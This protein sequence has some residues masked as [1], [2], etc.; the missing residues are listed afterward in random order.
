MVFH[1]ENLLQCI[2]VYFNHNPKKHLEFAKWVEIMEIK[3]NKILRNIKTKW[4]SMFNLVKHVLFEYCTLLMKMAL[5]APTI[6][7]T[8]S[9]LCLL[10]NVEMLLG[11]NVVMPLLEVMHSLIKFAQLQDMFMCDFITTVKI[12]E[13]EV[14]RMYYDIHS[15]F[16]GDVFMNF[17]PLIDCVHESIIFC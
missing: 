15:S 6:S 7:F 2:Y 12:C 9:N 1:I 16:Q 8:K 4:I 11:L 3:G 14:Y 10:I 13:G 5:D 17:Q